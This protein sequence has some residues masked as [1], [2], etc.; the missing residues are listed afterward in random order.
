MNPRNTLRSED[1][2]QMAVIQWA[3]YNQ[4][5]YP[6]LKWLHHCPNGGSRNSLEAIK[7]KQMG[8]KAGV[9]DLCLP[10]PCGIYCG[11]YIEMK[12]GDNRHTARQKEFLKDMQEAGHFVATCYSAEEAV[13]VIEEYVQ[14][15]HG[16]EE[17]KILQDVVKYTDDEKMRQGIERMLMS[18]PNNSILKDGKIKGDVA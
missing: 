13:K 3:L 10:Y 16:E 6:E 4:N 5:R 18:I 9:S 11:L 8:V 1:T 2:E 14:L 7:L 15:P 12:Y 17:E